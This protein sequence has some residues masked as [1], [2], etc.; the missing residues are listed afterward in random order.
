MLVLAITETISWGILYYAFSVFL[1]PMHE[2]LGWSVPEMTGAYSVALLLSGL[3]A[4]L[5]GRWL[6]RHGPRLSMTAGSC[7][8]VASL[9]LWSRAET[10]AVFYLAWAGIGIA[11][12]TT[13]YEPAFAT[14]AR[15][16]ERDRSRAM[17]VVTIAAGFASTIFLPVSSLLVDALGWR[18]ALLV[19]S[20]ILA[21]SAIPLHAVVLRRRPEDL[22]LTPDGRSVE[23][24]AEPQH[25][26][27]QP[28]TRAM[29]DVI[30]DPSFRWLTLAFVIQSFAASAVA[31]TLIPYLTDRGDNPAFAATAT[32]L[33]G[34]AQVVSRILSTLFGGRLAA[35]T[36]TALVF[37]LQAVAVATLLLWQAPASVILA[38]L[39]LGAGRGVVTLMRPLLIAEFYGR[40]HYGAIS[41]TQALFLT[42]AG[43][44]APVTTGLMYGVL[45]TYT[46]VLWAMGT[47][48][49][50]ATAAMLHLGQQRRIATRSSLAPG[51]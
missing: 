43:S 3:C 7:L 50:V 12:S 45:G 9:L 32:G 33:I 17:L 1:V 5:V 14:L 16:F 37:G 30:R 47:L 41:G 11:M 13:L 19:L 34:A 44:A 35:V 51:N 39:L 29:R 21:V 38:V 2:D 28:A 22:G 6:D 8:G 42:G 46:P 49:L 23:I 24:A 4:P 31:V 36:L 26:L 15:W 27:A 20:G 10:I 40:S 48:S 25:A 18:S